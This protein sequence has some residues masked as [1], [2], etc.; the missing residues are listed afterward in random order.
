MKYTTHTH[1][2][3]IMTTE[4]VFDSELWFVLLNVTFKNG[5]MW[6]DAGEYTVLYTYTTTVS[7]HMYHKLY[8]M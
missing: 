3:I 1:D 7:L 8:Y 6:K 2:G 5:F 4:T